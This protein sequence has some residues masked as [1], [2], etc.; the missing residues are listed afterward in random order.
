MNHQDRRCS[1]GE[2]QPNTDT[3]ASTT[4]RTAWDHAVQATQTTPKRRRPLPAPF[5]A[6]H[7]AAAPSVAASLMALCSAELLSLRRRHV[8][9]RGVLAQ[10]Q[11]TDVSH[12]SPS[13]LP[14][15][16]AGI[17]VHGAVIRSVITSKKCPAGACRRRSMWYEGGGGNP[18]CTII[19]CPSARVIVAGRAINVE[20]FAGRAPAPAA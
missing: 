5:A 18:R 9:Q 15:D 7:P 11:R 13:D 14:G 1:P 20:A 2:V 16:S 6:R 12:D 10:L 8:I 4:G 17:A 19:P 3:P